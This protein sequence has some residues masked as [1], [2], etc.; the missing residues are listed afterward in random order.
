MYF[1]KTE[2]LGFRLWSS[3]DLDL[4]TGLWGDPEVTGLIGGPFSEV[5]IRERLDMETANMKVYQVQYWPIFLLSSGEHVGCCGL[6]PY[7]LDQ[8]IYEIGFHLRRAF[9]GQGFA[10]ESANAVMEYAFEIIKASALFAGHHPKNEASRRALEKLG[11]RYINDQFYAPTGLNHPSYILTAEDF[12]N[13][14][15]EN[16]LKQPDH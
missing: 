16:K 11:F 4:A 2:R 5:Q 7:K 14:S 9:Q 3:T 8:R 10:H 13:Q 12:L 1:L 6:R 15:D